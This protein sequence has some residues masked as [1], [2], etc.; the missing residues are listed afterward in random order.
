MNPRI[1]I[2]ELEKKYPFFSCSPPPPLPSMRK[3]TH[4]STQSKKHGLRKPAIKKNHVRT[5]PIVSESPFLF[6]KSSSH[7][8]LWVSISKRWVNEPYILRTSNSLRLWNHFGK[9]TCWVLCQSYS[10]HVTYCP[11]VLCELVQGHGGP[12]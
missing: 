1:P 10:F 6:F 3:F 11:G 4:L 12:H 2:G 8:K 7:A 5:S 9:R